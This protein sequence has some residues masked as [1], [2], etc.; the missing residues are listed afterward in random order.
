MTPRKIVVIGGGHNG[1]VCACYLAAAGLEVLVLE[2]AA[3]AGGGCR[4]E[5]TI[6]GYRFNTHAAAHNIINMT[7]IPHELGLSEM[8]LEYRE[9]DPFAVGIFEDG[10]RV[11]FHRS[12]EA[13]AR[14]I[15][16][17]DRG[18]ARAYAAFMGDATPVV[19]AAVAVMQAGEPP[20]V[21]LRGFGIAL[22]RTLRRRPLQTLPDLLSPYGSLLRRRLPSDL[23]RAPLSAFAAH[24]GAGPDVIGGAFFAYWQAAYHRYGQWHPVG[25]SQALTDALVARL[26]SSGGELRCSAPVERIDAPQGRVRAVCLSDGT[27]IAADAVVA[28]IEPRSALL[29]LLDPPLTGRVASDLRA[30]HRSNAVQFVAHVATTAL[31]AYT[32][33]RPGDWNGLQSYVDSLDDLGR[34]FRAADAGHLIRPA[35]AYAFTPSALDDSLAPPGHHTVYLA[36]P[37]APYQIEQGWDRQGEAL[38]DDLV[39]QVDRRAPGFRSSVV[40][41][42]V[43]TPEAMAQ[44]LRWPGAHPMHIDVTLD[45]LG[46]RRPTPALA[47][48]GTPVQGLYIS[49]AGT[50]PVGGI[51]GLPGRSAALRLLASDS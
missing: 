4:T 17:I 19:E 46:P 38:A 7:S 10:R 48:H 5:E 29:D 24:A 39:E 33:S 13:T 6:P 45:Q 8:G 1:L 30:V 16:E 51:A 20:L 26:R 15:A 32:D 14:S 18:E 11:R 47:S 42:E 37:A 40:G 12:I 35:P 28:A 22:A 3:S 31:P 34:G 27:R 41:V 21:R 43:R 9:M 25:G 23:T 44:D 50:A 49:G 2:Q 36:C